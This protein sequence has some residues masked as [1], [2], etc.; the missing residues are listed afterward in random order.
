MK[1]FKSV[2]FVLL[3]ITTPTS[4][5]VACQDNYREEFMQKSNDS[6][7]FAKAPSWVEEIEYDSENYEENITWPGY[8]PLLVDAQVNLDEKIHYLRVVNKIIS[9]AALS[10]AS[11][12]PILF[13][14]QSAE[15]VVHSLKI[16]R[17]GKSIDKLLTAKRQIFYPCSGNITDIVFY[18]DNLHVGDIL[19]YS[20]SE[21]LKKS[22]IKELRGDIFDLKRYAIYKKIRYSCLAGKDKPL[23]WKTHLFEQDP[24]YSVNSSHKKYSWEINYSNIDFFTPSDLPKLSSSQRIR[25]PSIAVSTTTWNQIAKYCAALLNEKTHFSSST[26]QN[27]VELVQEW[28]SLYPNVE[29]QIL[30]AIRLVSD[31]IYYASIPDEEKEHLIT[32]YSPEE[33]LEKHYGDCKDKSCL[34]IAILKLLDVEAYPILT[35]TEKTYELKNELPNPF[36]NHLIVTIEY[37]GKSYFIDP[38]R[39]LIGGTLETYQ[40]PDFGYGLVLKEDSEDLIPITRNFLSKIQSASTLSLQG[41][42]GTWEHE[43]QLSHNIAD[44]VRYVFV[45][46]CIHKESKDLLTSL[47]NLYPKAQRVYSSPLQFEDDREA[48]VITK[49][50]AISFENFGQK[51]PTGT[52]FNFTPFLTDLGDNKARKLLENKNLSNALSLET[53]REFL[54]EQQHTFDI[55]CDKPSNVEEKIVSYTDENMSY[56]LAVEKICDTHIRVVLYQKFFRTF[57]E[58]DQLA[59]FYKKLEEFKNHL[60]LTIEIPD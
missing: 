50:F 54:E 56:S 49:N 24:L 14:P 30:A 36:F 32:P 11:R 59:Q 23:S 3:L 10:D 18:L 44:L 40:I 31:D 21:K 53:Y 51:T 2:Y 47:H 45:P 38:T 5:F 26:P 42:G 9:K 15:L 4:S 43:I 22:H 37:N 20:F 39:S 48:N 57:I 29:Y 55:Y 16:I 46:E 19:E 28:Q 1:I 58:V 52:L 6:I 17:D 8:V 34:L 25:E 60:S 41:L 27:I 13:H 35:H 7:H 12:I 33:I